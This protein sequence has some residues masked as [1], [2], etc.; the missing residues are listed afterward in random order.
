MD[1]KA[2]RT[3]FWGASS[4]I[5]SGIFFVSTETRPLRLVGVKLAEEVTK[6]Q[7]EG[8]VPMRT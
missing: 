4:H 7:E 2:Q 5:C 6:V 1:K 8:V 3:L